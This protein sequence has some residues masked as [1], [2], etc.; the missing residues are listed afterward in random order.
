MALV[1]Q[2]NT[3]SRSEN[4]IS[5]P[6]SLWGYLWRSPSS[7]RVLVDAVD[8]AFFKLCC[9]VGRVWICCII[10]SNWLLILPAGSFTAIKAGTKSYNDTR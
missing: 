6:A 7:P 10:T 1:W 9:S 8:P 3:K 4:S 5:L 2:I